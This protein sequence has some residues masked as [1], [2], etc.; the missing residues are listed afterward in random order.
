MSL[1]ATM[2]L[3][4]EAFAVA[5]PKTDFFL[6]S[7]FNQKYIGYDKV[8]KLIDEYE[9]KNDK[10]IFIP[11]IA[12][13]YSNPTILKRVIMQE[14]ADCKENIGLTEFLKCRESQTLF[15]NF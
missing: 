1:T 8:A 9:S 13:K 3:L 5:S 2:P 15:I 11:V 12:G 10:N 4:R 7:F 6:I 14:I